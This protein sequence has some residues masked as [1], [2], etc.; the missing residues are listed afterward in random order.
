V[1]GNA[2]GWEASTPGDE[3]LRDEPEFTLLA[4]GSER[5]TGT[6]YG[7]DGENDRLI[8]VSK[9]N[10]AFVAQYRLPGRPGWTE[11]RAFYVEPGIEEEPDAI[12]WITKTAIHRTILVAAGPAASPAP[13]A[14]GESEGGATPEPEQ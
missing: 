12:V 9:V 7:F 4:S 6:I 2:A 13:S 5:R 14:S 8:G 3:I 1:N 11:L 10:G